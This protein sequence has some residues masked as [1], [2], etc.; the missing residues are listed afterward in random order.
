MKPSQENI[1]ILFICD[2]E[3]DVI[4]MKLR[5][6]SHKDILFYIWHCLTL[7]E[8]I[9]YLH[10]KKLRADIIIL[11]LELKDD[12]DPRATY[13]SMELAAE[14]VPIIVITG[15]GSQQHALASFVIE[16]GAADNMI[17][18]EFQ[19]IA[20]ALEFA[21]IRRKILIEK[22]RKSDQA[23]QENKNENTERER[24]SDEKSLKE[25]QEHQDNLAMFMGGYSV[26]NSAA[27]NEE[28]KRK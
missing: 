23:L 22:E 14:G 3:T 1:K 18:G 2:N 17:R 24:I 4:T 19:G 5:L 16:L 25:R 6:E 28:D 8:G 10:I 7:A 27:K 9:S 12:Q 21:L 15:T 20:D 13:R 11:D 26:T